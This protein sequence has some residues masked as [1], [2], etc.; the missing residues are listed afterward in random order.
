[1]SQISKVMVVGPLRWYAEGFRGELARL[2]YTP[3]SVEVQIEVV[4]R[5]SRWLAG[6]GLVVSVLDEQVVTHFLAVTEWDRQRVPTLR[7]FQPLLAW[8]RQQG[9]AGSASLPVLSAVDELLA[10][11]GAWLGRVR[12]LSPRTA[13]RYVVTARRFLAARVGAGAGPSGAEGLSGPDVSRFLLAE[14]HRG[15]SVGSMKGRVAE[16]CSLLRFLHSEGIIEADLA[17]AVPAVAGWRDSEIAPMLSPLQV[18]AMLDSC[19]RSSPTGSRDFAILTVLAR[20]GL[21]AGELAGLCLEDIDWRAGEIIIRRG[22][23]RRED[24]LPLLT[25]VGEALA[26]VLG[27]QPSGDHMPKRVRDP[28][29]AHP[30]AAPQHGQPCRV[31]RLST[32]RRP[33]GALA[34]APPRLGG[35]TGPP[36]SGAC[37]HWPGAASPGLGHHRQVRQ[38]RVRVAAPGRPALARSGP[39][40]GLADALADYLELRRSFGYK[41]DEAGRLLPRFVAYMGSVGAEVI[42]FEHALEWAQLPQAAPTTTV[43]ARRMSVVR[44]FA[45]YLAGIDPR[46]QVPPA[47]LIPAPPRRR[48]PFI[49]TTADVL[50]L[51][52]EA[53]KQVPSP[54]RAT[55]IATVIGLLAATGMRVGEVIALDRADIDWADNVLTV[56]QTK[57]N[58][59]R[60]VPFHPTVERGI[61]P[62]RNRTGPAADSGAQDVELF[63]LHRRHPPDLHRPG[64]DV[65]E[66]RGVGW[67][68]PRVGVTPRVHDLRHAFAVRALMEW[69]RR[70][71]DVQSRLPWLSTYL[72]HREPRYTYTYLTATPE[73]LA[74]A[75]ERL[76]HRDGLVRP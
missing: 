26:V 69:Y 76:E 75:A 44:G 59:A 15:L 18:Q 61:G 62:L 45:R 30:V 49:Y 56:R 66:T 50:L 34:Q 57:F 31:G 68:R 9:L 25:D 21:R 24:R 63:R 29:R 5:L 3:G 67:D 48:R 42:T 33:G 60:H 2:G 27:Q 72:G 4:D 58:K 37:R 32:G 71:D 38:G 22:K 41:L 35:R 36:G 55:T 17:S 6:E 12:G 16:L 65:Q 52:H 46:T 7:T 10:R 70:G 54:L 47:G 28:S 8:L 11:Y 40:T 1:M 14:R 74:L 39:V 53:A 51:Q 13:N 23:A 43:W 73:L 64:F 19:D 20:L